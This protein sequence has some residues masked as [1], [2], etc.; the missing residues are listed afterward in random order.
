MLIRKVP[1]NDP[2]SYHFMT[3]VKSVYFLL[4]L[5]SFVGSTPKILFGA[6]RGNSRASWRQVEAFQWEK[7]KLNLSVRNMHFYFNSLCLRVTHFCKKLV[8]CSRS[9]IEIRDNNF[10]S[11]NLLWGEDLYMCNP[12]T[13]A[14]LLLKVQQWLARLKSNSVASLMKA[15]CKVKW[16]YWQVVEIQCLL[17]QQWLVVL[18][19]SHPEGRGL[20]VAQG[21]SE[22][23]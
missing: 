7:L 12:N 17:L 18:V 13:K 9:K 2:A 19:K 23:V 15:R 1:R 16:E 8:I 10:L 14:S 4:K 11:R 3:T 20:D 6:L 22:P 21:W 5:V